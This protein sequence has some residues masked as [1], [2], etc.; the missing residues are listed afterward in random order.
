[1]EIDLKVNGKIIKYMDKENFKEKME[2]N[3]KGS[4]LKIILMDL[5]LLYK[6]T[7][8]A[9][10]AYGIKI[11]E[12]VK[13]RMCGMMETDILENGKRMLDPVMENFGG[14]MVIFM[15]ESG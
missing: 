10:K 8:I 12:M 5:V 13:E 1:M 14:L 2:I 11:K 3:I 6:A 7:V 9:M 15:K 4:G